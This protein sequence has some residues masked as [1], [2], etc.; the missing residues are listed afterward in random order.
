LHNIFE[1]GA[2]IFLQMRRTLAQRSN[3]F[4]DERKYERFSESF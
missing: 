1:Y 3:N 4:A 2:A